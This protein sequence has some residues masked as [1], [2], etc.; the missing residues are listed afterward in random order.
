[1]GDDLLHHRRIAADNQFARI[2][3]LH[4]GVI[5]RDGKGNRGHQWLPD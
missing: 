5:D 3:Q 4:C 1:M 2:Y